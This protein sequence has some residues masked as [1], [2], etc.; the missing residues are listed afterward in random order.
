MFLQSSSVQCP[1]YNVPQ[2]ITDI[3]KPLEKWIKLHRYHVH[4][5]YIITTDIFI[6]LSRMY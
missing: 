4:N 1:P 5:Y 2:Q 3:K 6:S